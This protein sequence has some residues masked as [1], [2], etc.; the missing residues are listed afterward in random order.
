MAEINEG[1]IISKAAIKEVTSLRTEV[2][3]TAESLKK[4]VSVGKDAGVSIKAAQSTKQLGDETKKLSI[5]QAELLKIE[6]QIDT[7]NARATKAYQDQQKALQSLKKEQND[8]LVLGQKDAKLINEQNASLKQLEVA[9]NKNRIAYKALADEEARGSKEGKE[10]KAIIDQQDASVKKLNG[11]LG[12]F[13]GNVGNYEGSI[14]GLKLELKAARDEMVKIAEK[15][16][17]TSKEFSDAS[18]KAGEIKDKISDL[19]QALKNSSNSKFENIGNSLKDVGSKLLNLDFEGAAT[20]AKQFA[21]VVK[22]LTFA[23]VIVGVQSF[24]NTLAVVGKAILTNPLF[25]IAGVLAA[26]ALAFKYFYDQQQK[27][28]ALAIERYKKEEE[29]LTSRYDKEIKLQKILGNQTFELEKAKQKIIIDSANKQLEELTQRRAGIQELLKATK[30]AAEVEKNLNDEKRK[31]VDE[32]TIA[33]RDAANEIDI[34]TAEQAEFE[35][36]TSADLTKQKKEDLFALNKFRLEIQIEGQKELSENADASFN[37]RIKAIK[38]Q[39]EVSNHLAKLERDEAL[40]QEKLTGNAI[41]LIRE[42]YQNKL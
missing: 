16:G 27:A 23:E 42:E 17:T 32:L 33:K 40:S 26:V 21:T 9:L 38:K 25:I 6:K 1:E 3:L 24:G 5:A 39:T 15:T 8:R 36:K 10:L 19:N 11:G 12:D 14:K 18:T 29:S 4:L 22:S 28:S 31:Q 37:D 35:R 2:E 34:I 30:F 20:S 7:V 13:T 41:L